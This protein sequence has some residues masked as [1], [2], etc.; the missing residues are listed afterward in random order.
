MDSSWQ[1]FYGHNGISIAI[2]AKENLLDNVLSV[3][4]QESSREECFQALPQALVAGFVKTGIE[5]QQ[6]GKHRGVCCY[7]YSLISKKSYQPHLQTFTKILHNY[8]LNFKIA[9]FQTH[10]IVATERERRRSKIA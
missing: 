6:K 10:T 7:V 5:L 2:F 9:H 4:P 3:I 8:T 1:I